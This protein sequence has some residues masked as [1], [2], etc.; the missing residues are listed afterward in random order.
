MRALTWPK[1]TVWCTWEP[2]FIY[3]RCNSET[4][5]KF[6]WRIT[7]STQLVGDDSILPSKLVGVSLYRTVQ[8]QRICYHLSKGI[9]LWL[10]L[11]LQLCIPWKR[12][13][14]MIGLCMVRML[15]TFIVCH[16]IRHHFPMI[17]CYL[18]QLRKMYM[19]LLRQLFMEK[20]I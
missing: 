8:H 15:L 10:Q 1:S 17:S 3:G 9:P 7:K 18:D 19:P 12:L 14:H 6:V 11:W 16:V 13:I 5:V 20:R 2:W 4:V